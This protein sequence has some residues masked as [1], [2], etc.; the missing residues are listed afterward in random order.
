MKIDR[1]E[2]TVKREKVLEKLKENR[3]IHKLNFEAATRTYRRLCMVELKKRLEEMSQIGEEEE[4]PLHKMQQWLVFSLI[5]PQSF[6][7]YY[8][9]AIGA[10]EMSCDE[11]LELTAEQINAWCND[12]W[13]WR[14]NFANATMS[15]V[16][17]DDEVRWVRQ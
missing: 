12:K 13:N 9:D 5:A 4:V 7:E 8:D 14:A 16:G 17:H 2:L 10:L 6:L 1:L 15:Y 3:E 11:E